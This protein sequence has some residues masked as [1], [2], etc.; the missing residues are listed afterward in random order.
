MRFDN[1]VWIKQGKQEGTY[2]YIC[3][4]VDD[5]MIWSKDPKSIMD[6]LEEIYAIKSIGR[7]LT[8]ISETISRKIRRED[9][10]SDVRNI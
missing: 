5:F 8:I 7:R 9:G 6:Q 10:A 2:H 1:D 3:T 4:H